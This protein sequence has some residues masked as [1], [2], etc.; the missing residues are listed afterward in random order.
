MYLNPS[1]G[2]ICGEK[3][4][5]SRRKCDLDLCFAGGLERGKN[6]LGFG[7]LLMDSPGARSPA[8]YGAIIFGGPKMVRLFAD[9]KRAAPTAAQ[10][11]H[12]NRFNLDS[13]GFEPG[14]FRM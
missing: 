11:M 4:W 14:L 6:V 2:S 5:F 9:A 3:T 13:P 1:I 10:L 8:G 7:L 12:S